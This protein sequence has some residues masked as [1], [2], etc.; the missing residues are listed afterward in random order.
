M[1]DIKEEPDSP[2]KFKPNDLYHHQA[3]SPGIV[4][5][6]VSYLPSDLI[7]E[8]MKEEQTREKNVS[9]H[10]LSNKENKTSAN[11]GASGVSKGGVASAESEKMISAK[12]G[13]DGVGKEKE[14]G[15]KFGKKDGTETK[16]MTNSLIEAK[17]YEKEKENSQQPKGSSVC[18]KC[19]IL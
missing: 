5:Q 17:K 19:L 7:E 12:G 16:M 2:E 14:E 3:D 10:P 15:S 6:A 4:E 18:A 11:V 13:K 8:K 9:K 1:K